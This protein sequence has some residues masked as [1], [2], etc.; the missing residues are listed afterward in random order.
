MHQGFVAYGPPNSA[1]EGGLRRAIAAIN[2]NLNAEVAA[3]SIEYLERPLLR[4]LNPEL[5]EDRRLID[6]IHFA[7]DNYQRLVD[8]RFCRA[9]TKRLERLDLRNPKEEL[10]SL[11]MV[12]NLGHALQAVDRVS[13][14]LALPST[15]E[16]SALQA[17]TLQQMEKSGVISTETTM[18]FNIHRSPELRSKKSDG[19]LAFPM[20]SCSLYEAQACLVNPADHPSTLR[21]NTPSSRGDYVWSKPKLGSGGQ[22]QKM[23]QSL[24]S[25]TS[26]SSQTIPSSQQGHVDSLADKPSRKRKETVTD[27]DSSSPKRRATSRSLNPYSEYGL[28]PPNTSQMQYGTPIWPPDLSF[29]YCSPTPHKDASIPSISSTQIIPVVSTT[30][31]QAILDPIIDP[32]SLYISEQQRSTSHNNIRDKTVQQRPCSTGQLPAH[33]RLSLQDLQIPV[34][35]TTFNHPKERSEA[36]R[37]DIII[38]EIRAE[39]AAGADVLAYRYNEFLDVFPLKKNEC[40]SRYYRDLI[41]NG[42]ISDDDNSE[43]AR[44]VRFAKSKWWNYWTA[45]DK[46][47]VVEA[48]TKALKS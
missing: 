6:M 30:A 22:P 29:G 41:A 12:T 25:S 24:K 19:G 27:P 21:N 36:Q 1:Y 7:K 42:V 43:A 15:N 32:T 33:Q 47:Y 11:A 28:L 4:D 23:R 26:P 2:T 38:A 8:W 31:G 20:S 18:T 5:I 45:K 48:M 44:T 37:R 13:A 10:R 14:A 9:H 34:S 35:N 3:E 40:T 17:N 16:V 46:G 39:I